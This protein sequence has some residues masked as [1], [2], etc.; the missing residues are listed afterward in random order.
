ML[1]KD[2]VKTRNAIKAI[3]AMDAIDAV[4][5]YIEGEDREDVLDAAQVQIEF[6]ENQ[7][8][9]DGVQGAGTT[10]PPSPQSSPSGGEDGKPKQ[11][12]QDGPITQKTDEFKGGGV[13]GTKEQGPGSPASGTGGVQGSEIPQSEIRNPQLNEGEDSKS[14][15]IPETRTPNPGPRTTLTG[16]DVIEALDKTALKSAQDH[17]AKSAPAEATATKTAAELRQAKGVVTCEDVLAKMRAEG[18]TV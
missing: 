14:D 16:Q 12:E 5:S 4:K 10:S 3:N 15:I 6:I 9:G 13:Q 8:S 7:G 18:K 1:S 11:G 2:E 17:A